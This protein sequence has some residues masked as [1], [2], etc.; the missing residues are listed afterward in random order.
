MSYYNDGRTNTAFDL[1]DAKFDRKYE[2]DF[3]ARLKEAYSG[4]EAHGQA[5]P[6][7]NQAN[8]P[9]RQSYTYDEYSDVLTRSGRMWTQY[10]METGSYTSDNKRQGWTYDNAGNALT[11]FDGTYAYDAA[12]RPVTFASNQ[13]WKVYPDWPLNPPDGPSLETQDT[14]D[15]TGQ[16]AR[17]V[18]HTREDQSWEDTEWGGIHYWMGE[19]TTT[20]YYVHST[21][22]GGRTIAE[23]SSNGSV[24]DRFVYSGGA[25]IATY[26]WA[27]GYT[28]IESTNPV[29]GAAITTDANANNPQRQEPDPLGRDLSQPIPAAPVNPLGSTN[30]KDRWMP[31]EYTWGPSAEFERG[32]TWWANQMDMMAIENAVWNRN[33]GVIASILNRNPNLGVNS[34]HG[35]VFGTEAVHYLEGLGYDEAQEIDFNEDPSAEIEPQN[36]KGLNPSSLQTPSR[37][38]C[39]IR[40]NFHGK[41]FYGLPL[42][43]GVWENPVSGAVRGLGF[44]VTT[45][46]TSGGIGY[47]G[48]SLLNSGGAW[49][50]NQSSKGT[51]LLDGQPE[52]RTEPNDIGFKDIHERSGA[53][54]YTYWDFPGIYLSSFKN[55]AHGRLDFDITATN[56]KEKCEL[57][58]RI[59]LDLGGSPQT[60][61]WRRVR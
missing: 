21:V 19:T 32:N 14:F 54:Q 18:S 6:P 13:T 60:V 29:T 4:V 22:L 5:A 17:Q 15:G 59:D 42:G 11:T 8:S 25:R 55:R 16:I 41:D 35:T 56:G 61:N 9:Y 47:I 2:F 1:N 38:P 40:V 52:A 39:Q 36:T 46:V 43:P 30:L 44:T 57:R 37:R 20:T 48:K 53:N 28:S 12:S 50:I 10:D 23:V 31:I 7:I 45:T 58:F 24:G 26:H 34:G 51:A 49:T 33:Q 3:S 27:G